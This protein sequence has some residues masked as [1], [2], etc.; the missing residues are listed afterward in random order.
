MTQIGSNNKIDNGKHSN[1]FGNLH[2][3]LTISYTGVTLAALIF[4]EALVL[5]GGL[6]FLNWFFRGPLLP[7]AIENTYG[8]QLI[9]SVQANIVNTP[10][11]FSGLENILMDQVDETGF[12]NNAGSQTQFVVVDDKGVSLAS[13]GIEL[14]DP[15]QNNSSD[16]PAV[17]KLTE[18]IGE[19]IKNDSRKS[20]H[21]Y[22][23]GSLVIG[24]PIFNEEAP[25]VLLGALGM[26]TPV[27]SIDIDFIRRLL[28]FILISLGVFSLGVAG[29]GTI[30]GYFTSKGLVSRIQDLSEI[31]HQWQKGDFDELAQDDHTDELAD[32]GK[33]MNTMAMQLSELIKKR[34]MLAVIEERNR[35]ARDLHDSVKQKTFAAAGQINGAMATM[36]D[37]PDKASEYLR[38]ADDLLH[39]IRNDLTVLINEL[40]PMELQETSLLD[41]IGNYL[42]NWSKKNDIKVDFASGEPLELDEE[43]ETAV[44]RL[45][46]EA[47]SNIARHSQAQ[48][49][50]VYIINSSST[51]EILIADDGIG[52]EGEPGS[53]GFGLTSIK[54]RFESNQAGSVEVTSKPGEG[55]RIR[56]LLKIGEESNG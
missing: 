55:T 2:W 13:T 17:Q 53:K 4:L 31:T 21:G 37:H 51:I 10:N 12:S 41:A 24:M 44:F 6:T 29:I 54:E 39:E 42:E 56:V 32:L 26:I 40:R 5:F 3:K 35:I 43:T 16:D 7:S 1:R 30:F 49:A 46:Q 23:N 25:Q 52:F 34:K 38:Q 14:A 22:V 18:V 9:R 48:H 28:P 11:D 50:W 19:I 47:T 27:P 45:I 36:N 8:R 33:Q 20:M 15:F